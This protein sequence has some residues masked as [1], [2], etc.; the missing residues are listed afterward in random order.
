MSE[1][2]LRK[3]GSSVHLGWKSQSLVSPTAGG[4]RLGLETGEGAVQ[5]HFLPPSSLNLTSSNT[6][7]IIERQCNE[8]QQSTSERSR[9]YL[10][11]LSPWTANLRPPKN[12][13]T[14]LNRLMLIV[15][16][17]FKVNYEN[18]CFFNARKR[19]AFLQLAP[20]GSELRLSRH[21]ERHPC[22]HH[23]RCND[24][25]LPLRGALLI[26]QPCLDCRS[27]SAAV[28]PPFN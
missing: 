20:S 3:S 16:N 27:W 18:D 21:T 5:P 28:C 23:P 17:A 15:F 25:C 7:I 13:P 6:T 4:A 12:D 2:V 19:N 9:D 10:D 22:D 14:P 11:Y 26:A 24:K 8:V 1:R